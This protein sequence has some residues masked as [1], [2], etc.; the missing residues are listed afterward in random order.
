MSRKKEYIR[1]NPADSVAVALQPLAK[2]TDIILNDVRLTLLEDIPQGHKFALHTIG[3]G[4]AVIKYGNP[5]GNAKVNI[6][7]GSWVHVHNMKT[8]LGDLV[9]Y[10]YRPEK[11]IFKKENRMNSWDFEGQTEV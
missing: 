3:E 4:E 5:I 8:G 9:D 1:I 6:S 2:G 10:S 7:K 11:R